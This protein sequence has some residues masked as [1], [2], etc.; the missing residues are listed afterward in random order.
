MNLLIYFKNP[1]FFY[2]KQEALNWISP[3][4][5]CYKNKNMPKYIKCDCKDII[6]SGRN[7]VGIIT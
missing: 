3:C 1:K 7:Q 4:G 2:N 6:I 5:E